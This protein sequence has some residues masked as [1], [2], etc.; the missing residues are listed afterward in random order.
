MVVGSG[1]SGSGGGGCGYGGGGGGGGESGDDGGGCALPDMV[2]V[3]RTVDLV[4]FEE[5]LE[6]KVDAVAESG[7]HHRANLLGDGL[8]VLSIAHRRPVRP[9]T[10]GD[11]ALL[12]RLA[13]ELWV[14]W[15]LESTP[16]STE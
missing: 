12:G 7:E 10:K 16:V 9:A 3:V 6:V 2:H 13:V 14:P 4:E 11:L 15:K 5:V 1:G 8:G